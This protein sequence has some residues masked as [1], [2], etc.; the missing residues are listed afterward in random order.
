MEYFT[1]L[2]EF[3][4]LVCKERQY[5]VLPSFIHS[6]FQATPQH[7]LE[8]EERQRI[9]KAV[10]EIDGLI[11][12]NETLRQCEFPFPPPTSKPIAALATPKKN[13]IQCTLETAGG[14]CKYI[15]I[16]R[17]RLSKMSCRKNMN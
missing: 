5:A 4:V 2:P 12:N 17:R 3:Q 13:Y 10:V 15:C 16:E 8:K 9:I 7:G 6:H 14:V 11:S 1:H